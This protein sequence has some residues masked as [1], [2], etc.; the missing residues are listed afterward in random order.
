MP[1][2]K[3]ACSMIRLSD[4]RLVHVEITAGWQS[5]RGLRFRGVSGPL[6]IEFGERDI[7]PHIECECC[8]APMPVGESHDCLN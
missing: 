4:G 8:G 6:V 5:V 1:D 2:R 7:V 3:K